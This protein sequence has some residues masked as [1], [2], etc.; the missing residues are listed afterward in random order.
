MQPRSPF[1]SP[2]LQGRPPM[3]ERAIQKETQQVTVDLSDG[4]HID[5]E[6]FLRLFEAHHTGR[7]TIGDLLN[8]N[9]F[10][11]PIKTSKGFVLLNTSQIVV[12]QIKQEFE[13]DELM[14]LGKKHTV[15][16]R[17]VQGREM[18]GDLY[19]N[20]PVE[21]SRVKDYVNQPIQFFSL[22]QAASILYINRQFILSVQD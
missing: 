10:F 3:D 2:H 6:F 21:S 19:V 17:T 18:S 14:T 11:I 22:Y 4:T 15:R 13:K 1:S 16:I 5:G 7:Q 12:V 20:L 8:Q 9:L